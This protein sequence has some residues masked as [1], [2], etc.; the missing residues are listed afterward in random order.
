MTKI[1]ELTASFLEK[2]KVSNSATVSMVNAFQALFA[3]QELNSQEQQAIERLLID[4]H[5]PINFPEEVVI[6]DIEKISNITKEVRA[7]KKQELVLIGERIAQAREVFRKYKEKSFRNWLEMTFGSFKTGYN[8]LAFHDLYL[9]F[10]EELRANLKGM[11]AK[12][13]YILASKRGSL[14]SKIKI[15][16]EHAHQPAQRLLSI[17]RS[18]FDATSSLRTPCVYRTLR[19][20]EHHSSL[21]PT[22]DLAREHRLSLEGIVRRLQKIIDDSPVQSV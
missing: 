20:L 7:I 12:A 10:P 11:P 4:G 14:D 17:I 6:V 16:R 19:L 8:Y 13:V 15:V 2:T 9:S 1:N 18:E 5:D 21:L 3:V 22:K